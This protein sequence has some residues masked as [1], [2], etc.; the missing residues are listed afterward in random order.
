MFHFLLSTVDPGTGLPAYTE[1]NHLLSE[2]RLLVLASTDTSAA[3]LCGLFF[4]LAHN[5]HVLSKLTNEIRKT[6]VSVEDITLGTK[7]SN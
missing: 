6:F 3:T 7:L 4:Y 2:A 1:R 5:P